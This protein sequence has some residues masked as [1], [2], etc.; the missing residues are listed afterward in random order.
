[1]DTA[2]LYQQ[3]LNRYVTAMRNEKPDRVPIRPFVAEFTAKYAGYSC[4]EVT[5]DYTKAFEA[6]VKTAKD[7]DW[8]AVVPNMVYVWTGLT[9]AVGLRYYGI[10]G[11]GIPYD[12]GFNYIEPPEEQ[13]F[14]RADEYDALI[15]DPTAFLYTVWLPRVSSEV[16]RPGTPSTYRNNLSFVKGAMAMLSYFYAFGPQ[17]ARLR[18]ECGTVSAIAGI[19]K[20]PFDILADKLRGYVGLT[21][22]MHTQPRKVLEACEALMPHL[23]HV[24]LTTADPDKRVPIGF[25]MHRG[26]VPFVNPKQFASHNWPTLKPIIEE[27][28]KQGHQTLFYAEGKWHHHFDAFRELP[29]RSIVFHCDQDDIFLTH[30]K[31]HDKFAL[32]GGIPNVLLSFG[33]PEEVRMFCRKVLE[34]VAEAGGY[35]MDAGAIMQNDTSIE[36]LQVMTAVARE[37]GSYAEVTYQPGTPTPACDLKISL[38]ERPNLRGMQGKT[39]APILPGVCLPW[40]TRARELPQITGRPELIERI[41]KDIDAFGHMYIWQLLL[42][43]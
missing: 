42:S 31:L 21:L 41:W 36:N 38:A 8:D 17:I 10:P 37:Y 11:L 29:Q 5:H 15:D 25:W 24:G 43:F 19:F 35:I 12:S 13:A 22:D 40:E 9:Q 14:M 30:Q 1:M 23:C 20:A 2:T 18:S 6:A 3:R 28:W 34:E 33:K 16:T 26:C 39:Q 4:Q 27:F 32:S 7:F